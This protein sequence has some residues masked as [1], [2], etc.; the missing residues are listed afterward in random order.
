MNINLFSPS[1]EIWIG[2]KIPQ[3]QWKRN[4]I[5]FRVVIYNMNPS[6]RYIVYQTEFNQ[7]LNRNVHLTFTGISE[8]FLN[9]SVSLC[10]SPA[11]TVLGRWW[12]KLSSF[13]KLWKFKVK[14]RNKIIISRAWNKLELSAQNFTKEKNSVNGFKGTSICA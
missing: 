12:K 9:S 5:C 13:G 4:D 8:G 14:V 3:Q 6:I 11:E 2:Y 7:I 1:V 10:K